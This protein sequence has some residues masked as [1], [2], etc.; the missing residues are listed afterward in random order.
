MVTTF[1]L[2]EDIEV[3]VVTPDTDYEFYWLKQQLQVFWRESQKS[4]SSSRIGS[5]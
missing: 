2:K 3:S 5:F 4:P 1:T